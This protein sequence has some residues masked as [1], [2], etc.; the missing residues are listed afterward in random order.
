MHEIFAALAQRQWFIDSL[1]II[2]L[3]LPVIFLVL[4][5][6]NQLGLHLKHFFHFFATEFKDLMNKKTSVG[7]VNLMCVIVITLFGV[8]IIVATEFKLILG[9]LSTLIGIHKADFFA[10]SANIFILFY[11]LATVI[12]ASILCVYGVSKQK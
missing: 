10:K 1:A 5:I 6:S 2:L 3:I 8:L 11:V 7:A 9:F 12:V 4:F